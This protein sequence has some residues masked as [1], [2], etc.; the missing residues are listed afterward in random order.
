MQI[1]FM[2]VVTLAFIAYLLLGQ[3]FVP[4]SFRNASTSIVSLMFLAAFGASAW[5]G[6]MFYAD[7][8]FN[9]QVRT[10]TGSIVSTNSP[11]WHA[12]W[13]GT[14]YPWKKAMSVSHTPDYASLNKD[15]NVSA[16]RPPYT[17]RMLDRVDGTLLETTRFRLPDDSVTFLNLASEYRTPDN[18]LRTELIPM[19]EQVTDATASLMSAEDYFNGQRNDFQV[20]F[21]YQM[22]NGIFLVE[23][24]EVKKITMTVRAS[25]ANA[26]KEASGSGQDVQKHAQTFF[27]VIKVKDP[28]TG[29]YKTRPH[30]YARF[31][32]TVVDAKATKF[33]PNEDFQGRM[34]L[35]QA[36][37]A[38]RAIDRETRVQE[39]EKTQLAIV[40]GER[41]IAE[42]Q[43]IVKKAQIRETTEAET[44]KQ[45]ALTL[46]SQMR[47]QAAI[48]KETAQEIYERDL[49]AAKSITVLADAEAYRKRAVIQADNAL[50]DKLATE[51]EIQKVWAAAFAKR[52]VPNMVFASGGS[53]GA[54]GTPVGGNTEL[55]A[56]MQ[57]MTMQM[58]K[59]LDYDR[60]VA[61]VASK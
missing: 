3:K 18:L 26:A 30:N 32:I 50:K 48:E 12:K 15:G 38:Q 40:R 43:A 36:A 56:I 59:S 27:E 51:V 53:G 14:T 44:T 4:E 37:S 61:T 58:A 16:A 1:F 31:G 8:G 46:A 60:T 33:T 42:E 28:D 45:L 20:D 54:G 21:D 49:I 29:L 34:K 24:R 17:I 6:A 10:I 35:Q 5:T 7:P 2:V 9:Y 57:M 19:V 41:Q 23:R 47:E 52:A 55:Q 11:G 22:R 39:E 13:F 25:T